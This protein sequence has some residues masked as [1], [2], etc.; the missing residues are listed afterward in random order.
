MPFFVKN[1]RIC[2]AMIFIMCCVKSLTN[3]IMLCYINRLYSNSVVLKITAHN[4]Q[5]CKRVFLTCHCHEIYRDEAVV[6]K[7]CKYTLKIMICANMWYLGQFRE[8]L[9]LIEG[10]ISKFSCTCVHI[11]LWLSAARHISFLLNRF[12]VRYRFLF[13]VLCFLP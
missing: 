13:P 5:K 9:I 11:Y 7:S 8:N 1:A 4:W 10:R 3:F 12:S 2:S 6:P